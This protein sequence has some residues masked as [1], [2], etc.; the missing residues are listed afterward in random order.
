MELARE[1]ALVSLL[2][3]AEGHGVVELSRVD[4][5]AVELGLDET[6]LQAL[7]DEVEARGVSI[8]DDCS[9]ETVTAPTF[10]DGGLIAS[11]TDALQL[12]LNEIGRYRLLT[13][14]EE[15]DLAKRVEKGDRAAMDHMINANLRLVVSLAR[16]YQGQGLPLL[17]LIQEG[18]LGLHRAVE[19]FD[20]RRGY[21]F[22]TYATWWIRQAIQRGIA[23]QARTIRMPVHVT[24]RERRI[25]RAE[26]E[27]TASLGRPPTSAEIAR[28][29]RLTVAQVREVAQAARAVT[30]LDRPV[31]TEEGA[32]LG[33]L[34]APDGAEL[35]EEVEISLQERALH[36][37]VAR[38]PELERTV[39]EWRYGL[40]DEG[41]LSLAEIGRRLDM[42]PERIRTLES[43]ALNRLAMERELQAIDAAA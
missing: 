7:Y 21:K 37:A 9:T 36:G 8:H 16:R 10:V 22:S 42:S 39:I 24:E 29:A 30:S 27:L 5:L 31:G 23:N 14:R 12:F 1:E 18:T 35:S 13:A 4:E 19:K 25:A 40:A 33:D 26:A 11:T 41:P 17:D 3:A 2:E 34:L 6:D 32:S 43:R 20:W 15:V 28:H 38:L